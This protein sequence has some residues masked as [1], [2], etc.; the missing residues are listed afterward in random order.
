MARTVAPVR[1]WFRA[2]RYARCATPMVS[3]ASCSVSA[4]D[5]H[6]GSPATEA[7]TALMARLRRELV[8]HLSVL[9]TA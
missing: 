2:A 9:S 4:C 8:W 5:Q 7:L 3:N 6:P 1:R